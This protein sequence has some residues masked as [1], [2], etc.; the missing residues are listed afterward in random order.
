MKKYIV[1]LITLL[2][3]ISVKA[4][5]FTFLNCVNHDAEIT[6]VDAD[7]LKITF[8]D[9]MAVITVG[10][11]VTTLE[12]NTLDYLEFTNTKHH[13]S[14]SGVYGDV[15]GDEKVD[16]EDVNAT[17]NIILELKDATDYP[18]N[19]DLNEDGKVD[20]EDVNEVINIILAV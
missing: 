1:L 20:V 3:L 5:I 19:A 12:L 8:S 13:G 11:Q 4:E 16:V 2:T 15:N 6:Q 9:G 10:D 7:G 14:I 17:I 18:G